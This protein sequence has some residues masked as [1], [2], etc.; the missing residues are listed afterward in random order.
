[1]KKN[2]NAIKCTH[3]NPQKKAPNMKM[4]GGTTTLMQ[5]TELKK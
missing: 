3:H 1:M 5:K 2:T 4:S